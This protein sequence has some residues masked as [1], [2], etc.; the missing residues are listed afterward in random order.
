MNFENHLQYVIQAHGEYPL[1]P[2]NATRRWDGKT[3]YSI[4]PIWC[5]MTLRTETSLP[6]ELRETGSIA[7]L[8]H[9]V[10]EDTKAGLPEDLP[11]RVRHLVREMTFLG[12]MTQE[13]EEI[14]NKGI[15][16]KLLKL[17]DKVSNLLD[18]SWMT[19]DR[20]QQ[21]RDHTKRLLDEAVATYGELN[22]VRIARAII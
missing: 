14:W 7:L 18:G 4:H 3:P 9:D 12:G 17:Y 6:E 19:A 1:R 2:E 13:M 15:E 20:A 8:Y 11:E 10:L 16:I 5:A 21:Y 22:I